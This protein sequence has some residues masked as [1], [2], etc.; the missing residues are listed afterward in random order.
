MENKKCPICSQV[1]VLEETPGRTVFRGVEVEYPRAGYRCPDCGAALGTQVQT[2]AVQK[3]ISDAYRKK[4]GLLPGS[5]IREARGRLGLSQKGLA[6]KLGVG[7]ASVKRW[8]T[9]AIQTEAMDRLLRQF[10]ETNQGRDI[11][12][13][14]RL[15]SLPRIKLVLATI[16]RARGRPLRFNDQMLF[17]A[18]Y[19]W[20]ADFVSFRE[21]GRGMTGASYAVLPHGPQLNNYKELVK[22][23]GRADPQDAEPLTEKELEIIFRIAK[24]FPADQDVIDAAHDEPAWL[25]I[26][27]RIGSLIPYTFADKLTKI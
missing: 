6:E 25:D 10:F 11:Y 3:A 26:R 9:G 23:I 15:I 2:E 22:E 21:I 27:D 19:A 8:E 16:G 13:G 5:E 17:T 20:Y 4:A 7:L 18:K 14:G 1:M 12:T 24:K